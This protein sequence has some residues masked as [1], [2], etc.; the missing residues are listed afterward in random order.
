MKPGSPAEE[1]TA[2]AKRPLFQHDFPGGHSH[3]LHAAFTEPLAPSAMGGGQRRAHSGAA[4]DTTSPRPGHCAVPKENRATRLHFFFLDWVISEILEFQS[5]KEVLKP[6][7]Q[8]STHCP[9]RNANEPT[10]PFQN[11]MNTSINPDKP[12]TKVAAGTSPEAAGPQVYYSLY[13]T[14]LRLSKLGGRGGSSQKPFV[15][16]RALPWPL[17]ICLGAQ[18]SSSQIHDLSLPAPAPAG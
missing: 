12:G 3:I 10:N 1:N 4:A 11:C 16:R 2:P 17:R 14:V 9:C 18:H 6:Q 8:L 13:S 15:K 5:Q 7:T